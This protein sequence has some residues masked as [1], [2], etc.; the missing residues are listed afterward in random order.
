VKTDFYT[1]SHEELKALGLK[2]LDEFEK[3]LKAMIRATEREEELK[4]LG[5][6]KLDEFYKI[7]D[8]LQREELA[9]KTRLH[10]GLQ[11]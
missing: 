10:A 2:K 5:I 1:L 3:I 7:L 8:A 9:V 11:P 6:Q 4:A